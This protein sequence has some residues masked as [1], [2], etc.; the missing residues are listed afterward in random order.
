MTKFLYDSAS[1]TSQMTPHK[2][3]IVLLQLCTY[4][5]WS[6]ALDLGMPTN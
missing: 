1:T 6:M 4:L 2:L 5:G 3:S